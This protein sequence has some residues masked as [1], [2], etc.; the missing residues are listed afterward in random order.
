MTQPM[1]SSPQSPGA[2]GPAPD[3][4][5][6]PASDPA[7]PSVRLRPVAT[8]RPRLP[9]VGLVENE[10]LKLLRRKRPQ[11]VLVVLAIFLGIST[12]AQWRQQQMRDR[13]N[14]DDDWRPRAERRLANT[15][16]R[17]QTR[18]IFVGVN[19]TLRFEAVRLRYHL[20]RDIDPEQRTGP[21]YARAFAGVASSLLLPLLVTLLVA[22]LVTS[23]RSAGTIKMLL[24]RPVSRSRVLAAKLLVMALFTSTLVLLSGLLS[25]L[26]A[27]IAFGWQGFD[28]PVLTGF[29]NTINGPDLTDVRVAP[30]WIDTLAAYGLAWFAALVV[31]AIGVTFSVL[32]RSTAAAMGTL[33]AL[34]VSGALLSQLASDWEPTKWIFVTNLPL[35]QFY[36]GVPPPVAGMTLAHSVGV[37]A[38]WGIGAIAVGMTVFNRRDV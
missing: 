6:P 26:I 14:P 18:R 24:T 37:L 21:L 22:D 38:V 15:E 3:P 7:A 16:R 1:S 8:G 5:A 27:G 20:E 28:A 31:G 10:C 13:F 34:V 30:L 17:M 2:Q 29:R 33:L 19:R 35:P 32:F 4:A 9:F 25:W 23:E 11:L 12:W 36:S